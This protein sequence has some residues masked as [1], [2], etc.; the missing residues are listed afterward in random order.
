MI[1]RRLISKP[2]HIDI[3]EYDEIVINVPA[4][5]KFMKRILCN[6][7]KKGK[8]VLSL[9]GYEPISLF[10]LPFCIYILVYD[11]LGFLML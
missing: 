9:I 3:H 5:A 4:I 10:S 1:E 7:I 6:F 11:V 2:I 8:V